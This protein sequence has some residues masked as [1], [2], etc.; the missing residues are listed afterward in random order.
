MNPPICCGYFYFVFWE[1][2]FYRC[3][4]P[5]NRLWMRTLLVRDGSI[6]KSTHSWLSDLAWNWKWWS[7]SNNWKYIS[8]WSRSSLTKSNPYHFNDLTIRT[9]SSTEIYGYSP[10][11]R[12]DWTPVRTVHFRGTFTSLFHSKTLKDT[13]KST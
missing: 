2:R 12:L 6:V 7:L 10:D 4:L 8:G 11:S 1:M 9:F 5:E 13:N 3:H